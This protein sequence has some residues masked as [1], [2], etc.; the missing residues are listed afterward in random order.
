[1]VRPITPAQPGTTSGPGVTGAEL[2]RFAA[3]VGALLL[4]FFLT[5]ILRGELVSPADGLLKMKPWRQSAGAGFE[6]SNALLSDYVFVFRPWREF[7]LAALRDGRIPLWIPY[8]SAGAP[9]LA[10]A[11]SAVLYPF[12]LLFL[13]LPEQP[14]LLLGLMGRLFIA[15]VAA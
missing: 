1:M 9:F 7:A 8:N 12:N 3:L 13:L 2:L 11:E 14:A 5:P 4:L 10:N 6:P 15:A